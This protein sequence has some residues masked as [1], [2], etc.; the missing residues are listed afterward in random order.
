MFK[1]DLSKCNANDTEI[2]KSPE[3]SFPKQEDAIETHEHL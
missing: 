2:S 1:L 3:K